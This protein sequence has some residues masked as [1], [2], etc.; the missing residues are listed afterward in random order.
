MQLLFKSPRAFLENDSFAENHPYYKFL[1]EQSSKLLDPS[2]DLYYYLSQLRH[3][4]REIY[5]HVECLPLHVTLRKAGESRTPMS[6]RAAQLH[7]IHVDLHNMNNFTFMNRALVLR[8]PNLPDY[9]ATHCTI[10]K[11]LDGVT[12]ERKS[13]AMDVIRNSIS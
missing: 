5:P 12:E 4:I 13:I 3:S 1:N 10:V 8:L 11:F 2:S 9:T 7:G 6:P